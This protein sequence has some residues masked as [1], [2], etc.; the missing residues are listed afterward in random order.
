MVGCVVPGKKR[1]W[2]W[3]RKNG[4]SEEGT[5]FGIG[6]CSWKH[7]KPVTWWDGFCS[8]SGLTAGLMQRVIKASSEAWF[9]PSMPISPCIGARGTRPLHL[10]RKSLYCGRMVWEV[11]GKTHLIWELQ[12]LM[13]SIGVGVYKIIRCLAVWW[14]SKPSLCNVETTREVQL[15]FCTAQSVML[16]SQKV[17]SHVLE[18]F[19]HL[20]RDTGVPDGRTR[21]QFPVLHCVAFSMRSLQ[22]DFKWLCWIYLEFASLSIIPLMRR[23]A[24]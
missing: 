23:S 24:V 1:P 7:C 21:P 17:R 13:G 6:Q 15:H 14:S 20:L 5:D 19:R 10:S 8:C 2:G 18:A 3:T 16:V 4:G 22:P 11:R 12:M 9:S